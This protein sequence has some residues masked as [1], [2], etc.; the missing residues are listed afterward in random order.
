MS[1]LE[2]LQCILQVK[3]GAHLKLKLVRVGLS[4]KMSNQNVSPEKIGNVCRRVLKRNV[5]EIDPTFAIYC[6]CKYK[7][8]F[9]LRSISIGTTTIDRIVILC[10]KGSTKFSIVSNL[11]TLQNRI[12]L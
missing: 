1:F 12:Y 9:N 10:T 3:N 4:L 7:V 2:I 6:Q 5:E 11:M 8:R